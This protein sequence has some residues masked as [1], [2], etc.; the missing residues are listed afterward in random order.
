MK[1][2][3]PR[4]WT[5]VVCCLIIVAVG[6]WGGEFK[7]LAPH[8][9]RSVPHIETFVAAEAFKIGSTIGGRTLSAVGWTFAEHFLAVVEKSVPERRVS[10]RTL[11]YTAGTNHLLKPRVGKRVLSTSLDIFIT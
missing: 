8:S 10:A 2:R 4:Q 5:L 11:L 9:E 1:E 7:L 3:R 6:A